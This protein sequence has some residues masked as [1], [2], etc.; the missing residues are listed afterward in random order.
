MLEGD[1]VGL[2]AEEGW[3][4]VSLGTAVHPARLSISSHEE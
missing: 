1:R 3:A 4:Q 2:V